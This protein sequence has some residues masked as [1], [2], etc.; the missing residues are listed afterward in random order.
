MAI[1]INPSTGI[2]AGAPMVSAASSKIIKENVIN[3]F[4]GSSEFA[5]D[6]GDDI[7]IR[8]AP[9]GSIEGRRRRT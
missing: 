9:R 4:G 6:A 8:T 7:S 3:G 1:E 5:S 2:T